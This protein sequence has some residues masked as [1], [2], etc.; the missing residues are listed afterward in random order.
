M[1][2]SLDYRMSTAYGNSYERRCARTK[3]LETLTAEEIE[4]RCVEM[5]R[6]KREIE[7]EEVDLIRALDAARKREEQKRPHT[8]TP[9]HEKR[10][11]RDLT[12]VGEQLERSMF[13]GFELVDEE[14]EKPTRDEDRPEA[15][16]IDVHVALTELFGTPEWSTRVKLTTTNAK[17][18]EIVR[19]MITSTGYERDEE[20][21]LEKT[22]WGIDWDGY[23]MIEVKNKMSEEDFRAK[24]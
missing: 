7:D 20:K 24:E 12:L 9:E 17:V 15:Y 8:L 16:C 2:S 1:S 4:K 21:H 23:D 13:G 19:E 5:S 11:R 10:L 18:R 14:P 6:R 22:Y 3:E